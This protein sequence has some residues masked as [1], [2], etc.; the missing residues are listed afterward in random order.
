MQQILIQ[1]Y[2]KHLSN[3]SDDAKNGCNE[4]DN[5]QNGMPVQNKKRKNPDQERTCGVKKLP[6]AAAATYQMDLPFGLK[7]TSPFA[8]DHPTMRIKSR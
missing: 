4:I 5:V 3:V 6:Q 2:I 7:T 8:N 1:F